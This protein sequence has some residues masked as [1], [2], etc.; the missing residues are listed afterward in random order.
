MPQAP[1]F[2]H[3]A[4]FMSGFSRCPIAKIREYSRNGRGM[5]WW[6]DIID[7]VGGYPYEAAKPESVFDFLLSRNFQLQR[8]ITEPNH[9]C[10]QFVFISKSE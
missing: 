3:F 1:C 7:W 4:G 9:G 5:S 8:L 2:A 6:Y 10:N